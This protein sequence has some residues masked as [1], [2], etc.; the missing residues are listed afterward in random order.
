MDKNKEWLT[1]WIKEKLEKGLSPDMIKKI[2]KKSGYSPEVVDECTNS[3]K[4]PETKHMESRNI[5]EKIKE[6][7]TTLKEIEEKTRE[8]EPIAD[9]SKTKTQVKLKVKKDKETIETDENKW[10]KTGIEGLDTLFKKGIPRGSIILVIGGPGSGKTIF[11]LQTLYHAVQNEEKALYMSFEEEPEKLREH[12]RDFGWDPEKYEREGLLRIKKYDPLK[13]SKL[14][15]ALLEKAE[16]E[17]KIDIPPLFLEDDFKPDRV[18]V[19]SLTAITTA[20]VGVG[21][22]GYYRI[23]IEQFFEQFRNTGITPF[24]ITE[25]Q[26]FPKR[27]TKSGVEEFLADGVII[28]HTFRKGS[29]KERGVEIYKLR[30]A[31]FE[32]K[33]VAIEIVSDK[34]IVVYPTQEV[35]VSTE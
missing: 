35:F 16:G 20:F 6:E 9:V 17:L 34:G 31:D 15:E 28:L 25:S 30:G 5:E 3:M 11:C 1:N 27:L 29:H 4:K 14:I 7:K 13:I 21:N 10:I 8:E 23:Y 2:L 33:I 12:M 32:E 22:E 18:F 19:D 24:L 26:E